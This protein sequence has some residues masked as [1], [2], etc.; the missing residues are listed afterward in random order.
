MKS[1]VILKVSFFPRQ[2]YWQVMMVQAKPH[3]WLKYRE[4]NM[5]RKEEDW[6]TCI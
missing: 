3:L 1:N 6:N 2:T 4:Q 5:A